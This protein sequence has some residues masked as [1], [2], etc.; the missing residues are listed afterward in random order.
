MKILE[1]TRQLAAGTHN[2]YLAAAAAD[3][4]PIIGY[5]CAYV[6][7]EIIHAAGCVPYRMRAVESTGTTMGDAWFSS[8]N[9][10]FVRHCFDKAL[11]GDF[12]F[13]DGVIFMNG[14]DHL[15][16][17]YDNWRYAGIA[18]P[19]LH[20]F[21]TPHVINDS[22][23]EQYRKEFLKLKEALE[24]HLHIVITDEALAASTRLY[25]R[26]RALLGELYQLRKN[27][28]L[29]IKGSEFLAIMLAVTAVPVET[30]IDIVEQV[31]SEI[32]GRDISRPNDTRI[33]MAA[34]HME[35][36]D[37]MELL[38]DCGAAIV[39]D[40]LCMGLRHFDGLAD[41]TADC[42]SSL[43]K[44]YLGHISCPRMA[45]DFQRRLEHAKA[46]CREYAIEAIIMEKIKFC[47]MWGGEAF[48]WRNEFKKSGF[49]ILVLERELYG[50][51][52]GQIRTRVQAFFEQVRNRQAHD[53]FVQA[54]G[55]NY[56]L[57]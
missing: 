46:A 43:A 22:A 9:C 30:A 34:G 44:R 2:E 45:N 55:K 57:K 28:I 48:I 21:V 25:N 5:F 6:P 36:I 52:T 20:M 3:G 12:A 41:E 42:V 47:D 54:A 23:R 19:F 37:H 13:L 4:K 53:A 24:K 33:F 17:V 31:L 38:E 50:G 14:C 32:K 40:N 49:P 18:T 1:T 29:P 7:E 35:E 8:I 39:G 16:R 11:K 27:T 10:T 51:S 15:R 26:K 56:R